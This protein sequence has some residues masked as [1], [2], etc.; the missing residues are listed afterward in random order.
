MGGLPA[1]A[2][3]VAA[4]IAICPFTGA[5]KL[6]TGRLHGLGD[7]RAHMQQS[8]VLPVMASNEQPD[9][10]HRSTYSSFTNA[11]K[12][13]SIFVVIVLLCLYIFLV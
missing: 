13:G 7:R 3:R 9:N 2:C 10:A 11:T 4:Q 5:P 1:G 6:L 12:W 8:R